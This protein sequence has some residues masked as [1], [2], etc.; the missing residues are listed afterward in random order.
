[1]HGRLNQTRQSRRNPKRLAAFGKTFLD[2]GNSATATTSI[3]PRLLATWDQA[4]HSWKIAAGTY[5]VILGASARESAATVQVT[6][7]A[8]TLPATWRRAK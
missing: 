8:R 2:P 1:M 5:Q 3:D 4:S 7:K 6:L